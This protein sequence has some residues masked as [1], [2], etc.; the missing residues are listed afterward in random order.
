MRTPRPKPKHLVVA[1][2]ACFA[3]PPASAAG[4][5][6]ACPPDGSYGAALRSD[7]P[8]AV[9]FGR[10]V[11]VTAS[12]GAGVNDPRLELLT[13]SG[14][15]LTVRT[16][17]SQDPAGPVIRIFDFPAPRGGTP[18]LTARLSF[19]AERDG[20]ACRAV[21]ART[22]RLVPG[23]L[24]RVRIDHRPGAAAITIRTAAGEGCQ[25]YLRAAT[26][27]VRLT[28]VTGPTRGTEVLE[29]THPCDGWAVRSG[30][31]S[32]HI[33]I[34]ETDSNLVLRSTSRPNT[35]TFRLSITRSGRRITSG[36]LHVE[37]RTTRFSREAGATTATYT[38]DGPRER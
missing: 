25:D 9:V 1:L 18:S 16:T 7:I 13:A 29:N 5:P 26:V 34:D 38:P 23:R 35:G 6:P 4:L 27:R 11:T 8:A 19:G 22:I 21:V 30:T 14:T 10:S 32:P 28:D 31:R 12:V 15:L 37:T 20:V 17:V 2:A 36:T 3:L 33:R 24:G